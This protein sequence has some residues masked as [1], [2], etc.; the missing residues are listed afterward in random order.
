MLVGAIVAMSGNGANDKVRQEAHYLGLAIADTAQEFDDDLTQMREE[1]NRRGNPADAVV[2]LSLAHLTALEATA[3][4]REISFLTGSEGEEANLR[5]RDFLARPPSKGSMIEGFILGALISAIIT[6]VLV[7]PKPELPAVATLP[8]ISK[9]PWAANLLLYGG[10]FYALAGIFVSFAGGL[11]SAGAVIRAREDAL[12][13]LRGAFT[14]REAPRPADVIRRIEDA[15][16]VFRARVGDRRPDSARADHLD[17][18]GKNFDPGQTD[19]AN[20][21]WRKRDSSAQFVESGFQ[22][23][24]QTWRADAY[25]KKFEAQGRDKTGSKRGL[26]GLKKP[27]AN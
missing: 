26:L 16:D 5:F 8:D 11:V 27:P 10:I 15:V 24:P 20:P 23:A 19:S 2:D 9:Y 18:G 12:A 6:M 14:S 13:S 25:A 1:M 17:A 22:S 21:D 3:Y 4:F 7:G